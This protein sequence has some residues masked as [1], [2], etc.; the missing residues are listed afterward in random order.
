VW[1]PE[2]RVGSAYNHWWMKTDLDVG[3]AH[4]WVSAYLSRWGN[5]E[6]KDNTGRDLP[7]C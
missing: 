6:A 3:P 7:N 2:V 1:G 4:Q 5:D